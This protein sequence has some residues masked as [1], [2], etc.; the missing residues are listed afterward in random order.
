MNNMEKNFIKPEPSL[1][2]RGRFV[3]FIWNNAPRFVLLL[4]FALIILLFFAI[5]AKQEKMIQAKASEVKEEKPPVNVVT[6]PL[7]PGPITDRLNLPGIV[8]P[9]TNLKLLAKIGGA[10]TKV[11]VKEGDHVKTGDILAYIDADDYRIGVDRARATFDLARID[12]ERDEKMYKKG[13]IPV[14]SLDATR[15]RMETARADFDNAKLMLSRTTVTSPMNGTIFKLDAKVGLQLAVGDPIA[16]IIDT[17]RLKGVV[18][19]PESD[20][21]AIHNLD[22]VEITIQALDDRRIETTKHLLSPA[23]NSSARLYNL[24]LA[25]DNSAGDIFAGMFLRADVVKKQV[26]DALAVPLFA[27]ITRNDQQYVFVEENGVAKKRPV[28]VGIME[29]WLIQLTSGVKIGDHL[30]VEGHREVEDNQKIKVVKT[31]TSPKELR[32]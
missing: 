21:D 22:K 15:A 2:P 16:D 24:E 20:V 9:W 1:T 18:G 8:E 13:A 30:L 29:K 26:D 11:A 23:P 17:D 10:I 12:F 4:F 31:I 14:A 28:T 27:V 5:Q 25:I 19:I 6:M 32:L 3:F 7:T